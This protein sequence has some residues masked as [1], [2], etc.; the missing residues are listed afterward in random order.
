MRTALAIAVTIIG[1]CVLTADGQ[2]AKLDLRQFAERAIKDKTVEVW[3]PS[4]DTTG[5]NLRYDLGGWAVAD[6]GKP[7]PIDLVLKEVLQVAVIRGDNADISKKWLAPALDRVEDVIGQMVADLVREDLDK[8]A[9]LKSLTKKSD[10]IIEIY[11]AQLERAAKALGKKEVVADR[12]AKEYEVN[13]VTDPP[14]GTITYMPAGRWEL[15]TFLSEKMKKKGVPEPEWTAVVQ[16]EAIP[17]V[18]QYRFRV[19]WTTGKPFEGTVEIKRKGQIR[20]KQ[21]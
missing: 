7:E 15:Y 17:L 11:D 5:V 1:A 18:G 13:L 10:R 4:Y 9:L 16:T 2:D 12:P 20:F 3:K 19:T 14:G 6:P 21:P 8:K